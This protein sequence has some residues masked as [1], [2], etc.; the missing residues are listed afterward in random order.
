[1]Q[2]VAFAEQPDG[3]QC[4]GDVDFGELAGVLDAGVQRDPADRPTHGLP[5]GA[6]V[7]AK[8]D[9]F[10]DQLVGAQVNAHDCGAVVDP[11]LAGAEHP[12]VIEGDVAAKSEKQQVGPGVEG[13]REEGALWVSPGSR[14]TRSTSGAANQSLI[15]GHASMNARYRRIFWLR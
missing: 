2:V 9:R 1:M 4:L 7:V 3:L 10:L 12:R 11:D 14:P 6:A 5:R 13:H 8:R 15:R